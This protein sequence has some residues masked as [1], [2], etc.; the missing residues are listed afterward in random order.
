V[1]ADVKRHLAPKWPPPKMYIAPRTVK[2]YVNMLERTSP[3]E[4]LDDFD[5][6]IV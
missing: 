3:A 4:V 2:H 6:S 1:A 5:R